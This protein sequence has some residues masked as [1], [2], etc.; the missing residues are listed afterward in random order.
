MK[1][2][3]E[4]NQ[5]FNSR[6]FKERYFINEAI[7]L[8]SIICIDQDNKN[9]GTMYTKEALKMAFDLGL[10]L[11][12]VNPPG[13]DRLATCKIMNFS[14]W[15]YENDKKAK[16]AAKKQK[17]QIVKVKEIKL[18]PNI[19]F[20]DLALKAKHADEFLAE[21]CKVQVSFMF[22][23]RESSN[24]EVAI[25]TL[26]KFLELTHNATLENPNQSLSEIKYSPKTFNVVLISKK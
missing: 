26:Q 22:K 8:N 25:N 10:D 21:G 7:R 4:A 12:Q 15:K 11:V 3:H 18:R 20:N 16:E 5:N 1:Y 17:E 13:K 9:L 24:T 19:A 2:T 23:G 6:P 14:K